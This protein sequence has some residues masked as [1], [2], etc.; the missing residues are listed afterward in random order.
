MILYIPNEEH[1]NLIFFDTE[2]NDR[3]LVQV[4]MIIY[5][6][7]KVQETCVYILKGSVNL[8]IQNEI[9]HFFTRYTGIT[10]DFLNRNAVSEQEAREKLNDFLKNYNNENSLFIAHGVKQDI[11]LLE[12]M[13]VDIE[14]ANRFCTYNAAKALLNREKNLKLIDICNE[15]GYFAE[16]HDAYSDAKNVVH[17]FSFLKLVEIAAE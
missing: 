8:Y 14:K 4:S 12:K 13:G 7:L 10:Q 16:Q 15:S 6:R 3:R 2:F 5:E 1:K 17:A 11:E 9:N